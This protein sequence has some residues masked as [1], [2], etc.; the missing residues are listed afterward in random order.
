MRKG[1]DIPLHKRIHYRKVREAITELAEYE[2]FR[3]SDYDLF[4]M[5]V[6]ETTGENM[7]GKNV[8]YNISNG[9]SCFVYD[10]KY[11]IVEVPRNSNRQGS[12][13]G[14]FL[15]FIYNKS[16]Q[17]HMFG[18]LKVTLDERKTRETGMIHE[19]VYF[20]NHGKYEIVFGSGNGDNR[21][22][23]AE[24]GSNFDP[25]SS[26]DEHNFNFDSYN[27]RKIAYRT[28]RYKILASVGV[29]N[30]D[31]Y[32]TVGKS[33]VKI[34]NKNRPQSKPGNKQGYKKKSSLNKR[35]H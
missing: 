10:N 8:S 12:P 13:Y 33:A 25:G 27:S 11:D 23:K 22:H 9:R 15:F 19:S 4:K 3:V 18:S 35:F 21:I 2:G 6:Y 14:E 32:K 16:F 7:K 20:K 34:Y 29:K 17:Y 28:N 1:N 5:T 26:S 31:P 24:Y 30:T